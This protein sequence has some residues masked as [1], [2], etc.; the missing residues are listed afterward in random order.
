VCTNLCVWTDGY[1]SDL[2]IN[3]IGQLKACICTLIENYNAPYHMH[4]LRK[5]NEYS[6]TEKQFAQVI[7]R[8]RMYQ[9]L[10]KNLQSDIPQFLFGDN[11]L[12]A[13]CKD[14]YRDESFCRDDKG[15]INLWRLYNLFTGTNKSTYIDNFIDKSVNAFQFTEQI[16]WALENKTQSWFLS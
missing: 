13:V 1:S 12:S 9:H 3:N 10:P 6:L 4:G 7:G 11:Q 14:Y 8:C 15:N 2:K 16:R 5:L